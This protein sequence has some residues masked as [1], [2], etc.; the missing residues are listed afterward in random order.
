MHWHK[1]FTWIEDKNEGRQVLQSI[2]FILLFSISGFFALPEVLDFLLVHIIYMIW[3]T[4]IENWQNIL[5]EFYHKCAFLSYIFMCHVLQKCW[6]YYA[7]VEKCR[8]VRKGCLWM[9]SKRLDQFNIIYFA[10][11]D[12]TQ[13]GPILLAQVCWR[14]LSPCT[15]LLW[16]G[17][18]FLLKVIFLV[19]YR[20]VG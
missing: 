18:V 10:I 3:S 11:Q 20:I 12:S 9:L 13:G 16:N 4:L 5:Q 1:R 15:F 2:L 8:W 19:G 7:N 6:F 17:C 14:V